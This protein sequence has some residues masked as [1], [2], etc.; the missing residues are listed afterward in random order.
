MKNKLL[1]LLSMFL[2]I[3]ML[4][5]AQETVDFDWTPVI[6][7]DKPIIIILTF[8]EGY[9]HPSKG[10]VDQMARQ[11]E[12]YIARNSRGHASFSVDVVG[13]YPLSESPCLGLNYQ[14]A[15]NLAD[16]DID[17]NKNYESIIVA[18]IGSGCG[19]SIGGPG[20]YT[21]LVTDEGLFY[22]N[23]RGVVRRSAHVNTQTILHE[24]LHG[25]L[26]SDS[27]EYPASC[28]NYLAAGFHY[29]CD[30][31]TCRD[32]YTPMS[33]PQCGATMGDIVARNKH[34]AGWIVVPTVGTGSYTIGNYET[35]G[36]AIRVRRNLNSYF[37]VE[38]RAS[39][40]QLR[41][42]WALLTDD[43]SY[44]S[45][46]TS[47]VT[48]EVIRDEI[49]VNEGLPDLI[50]PIATIPIIPDTISGIVPL[51][52]S[53]AQGEGGFGVHFQDRTGNLRVFDYESPFTADWNTLEF[54]D[55]GNA[56]NLS[57]LDIAGNL[58]VLPSQPTYILNGELPWA[59]FDPYMVICPA[60]DIG[61]TIQTAPG[62]IVTL[63][64][65][66]ETCNNAYYQKSITTGPDGLATFYPQG[67]G[68]M[69]KAWVQVR[70]EMMHS[71]HIP[72]KS[73]DVDGNGI[74]NEDDL[75]QV[76]HPI[77]VGAYDERSDLNNDGFT[78]LG[79]AVMFTEHIVNEH[80]CP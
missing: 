52:V 37:Y 39:G 12:E 14:E 1:I 47:G 71:G 13:W 20:D 46:P 29:T 9:S 28:S 26:I 50:L 45:D 30:G 11:M 72:V 21:P 78:D 22:I 16:T 38:K 31:N 80:A 51:S 27:V 60:G 74:C 62:Q 42:N 17:F 56:L 76:R 24:I 25:Y 4:A 79:D 64:I 33:W 8:Q 41:H 59:I 73:P 15:V 34:A 57:L 58:S 67:G 32:T 54:Y 77:A 69:G 70:G 5:S 35:T 2:L 61:Y 68:Y 63:Q 53:F 66:T 43:L 65:A 49:I 75:D 44:F 48:I 6:Q 10:N 23:R 3:P 7:G 55:G 18:K 36:E 40:Y 19:G